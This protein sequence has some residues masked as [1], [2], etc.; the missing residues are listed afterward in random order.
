[1]MRSQNPDYEFW[2]LTA[3]EEKIAVVIKYGEL[4]LHA[5][6]LLAQRNGG[7]KIRVAGVEQVYV[8]PNEHAAAEEIYRLHCDRGEHRLRPPCSTALRHRPTNS[9]PVEGWC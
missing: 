6:Y 2:C 5:G 1:M 3:A 8:Y 9:H 7:W 4:H